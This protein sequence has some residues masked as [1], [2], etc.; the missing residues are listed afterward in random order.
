MAEIRVEK[1]KR[2][3]GWLWALLA[4]L[5]LALI[6]WW[7]FSQQPAGELTPADT[8][9]PIDTVAPVIPATGGTGPSRD[10][11]GAMLRTEHAPVLVYSPLINGGHNGTL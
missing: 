6:A 5:V 2:G 11:I 4:L 3:L 8:L 7:F 1:E 10:S 9:A